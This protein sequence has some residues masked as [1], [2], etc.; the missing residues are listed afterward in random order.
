MTALR[1][2]YRYFRLAPAFGMMAGALL[3]ADAVEP[4][5]N[6]Q[7]MFTGPGSCSSPSCH[8]GVQPRQ[9]T[10]VLQNE[11]S[12]W[13]IKDKHTKAFEVL[14]NPI[15][16]RMGK[17]L[18]IP[19]PETASKCLTCHSLDVPITQRA[20]TF[21]NNDGVSCENCH[22]PASNWLGPHTTRDWNFDK[23]VQ[24]GMYDTR[25]LI[26]RTEKCLSC[27]LG[28]KDKFVD[29]KMIAAGHPDLYFEL[30]SFSA[31]MPR[32]WKEPLDKDPW[33]GV[34]TLATG[35]AVQL[36]EHLQRLVRR[37]QGEVWPEYAELDCYACHHSLT[38][39]KDSWRQERGYGDR[40]PG[41]PPFNASR[42]V[43]F[44]R[45]IQEIEP[46]A[47]QQLDGEL[48]QVAKLVGDL[49][50]DRKR[51]VTVA[52]SGSELAD[53]LAKRIAGMK[54]DQASAL[55]LLKSISG[56]AERISAQGERAA[57]QAAMALE[58]LFVAYS[59][60]AKPAN[61]EQLRAAINGLFR[62]L[63]DPSS[64][65]PEKFAVQMRAVN[66]LL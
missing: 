57:E 25:D 55:R 18:G 21:D 46:G 58:S 14:T 15:G 24:L 13:V 22:G 27:H 54:F 2:M 44:Q 62:Q 28:D 48:T 30:D 32:H 17:I 7:A 10:S 5:K 61:Q 38:A 33:I 6:L 23:S 3:A 65:R 35:Q 34:R 59:T 9:D 50:T 36:R 64:Y 37:A 51:L 43:V 26:K 11:Y 47:G 66:A 39:A 52:S 16:Q 29:H 20:R 63:D 49:A 42:Y 8:G 56:D 19:H 53:R 45:V 41:V 1:H 60:T 4:A 40:T 31:V 12:T